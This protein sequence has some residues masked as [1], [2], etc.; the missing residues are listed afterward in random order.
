MQQNKI[1]NKIFKKL[2]ECMIFT[3]SEAGEIVLIHRIPMILNNLPFKIL[4]VADLKLIV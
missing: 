2:L 4:N 1:E 3:G